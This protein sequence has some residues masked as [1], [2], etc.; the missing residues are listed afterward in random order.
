MLAGILAAD[1]GVR[2]LRGF[3]GAVTCFGK[4]SVFIG[5]NDVAGTDA[6]LDG[7][8]LVVAVVSIA[9]AES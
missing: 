3:V 2:Q 8:F 7:A 5:E 6:A 1:V 4:L 9:A